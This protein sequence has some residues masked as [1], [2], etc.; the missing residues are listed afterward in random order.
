MPASTEETAYLPGLLPGNRFI[1]AL[2]SLRAGGLSIGINLN[3]GRECNF[4]CLYCNV[5]RVDGGKKVGLDIKTMS[6]ELMDALSLAGSGELQKMPPFQNAPPEL[7]RLRNVA[8]SGEGE[9]TLC[10]KFDEVVQEIS[11]IRAIPRFPEFK[12]VLITNASGLDLKPVRQGLKFFATTDEIWAKLDAGTQDYMSHVNRTDVTLQSILSN[13]QRIGCERPI[14]IQGLFSCIHG[15]GP[16]DAEIAAYIGRLSDL[17]KAGA[18]ISLVQVH[19]VVRKPARPGCAHLS[20][21]HLSEIARRVRETT[22]LKAN[23]F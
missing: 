7:M 23:V 21:A 19:S 8:L 16:S 17:K 1:Y 20:L 11:R 3:P 15:R 13:I 9:P 12:L 10:E 5:S 4:D 2:I 18:R 22:G 14:V 6:R